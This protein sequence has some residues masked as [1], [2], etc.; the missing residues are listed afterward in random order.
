MCPAQACSVRAG[1]FQRFSTGISGQCWA[2]C[3]KYFFFTDI[4]VFT[5]YTFM[6][7]VAMIISYFILINLFVVYLGQ[8]HD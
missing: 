7:Q 6:T 5:F 1:D 3:E 2:M 8:Q 4:Q